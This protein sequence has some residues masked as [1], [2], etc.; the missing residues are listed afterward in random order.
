MAAHEETLFIVSPLPSPS[1]ILL[2]GA[3][4][5]R[6]SAFLT[7]NSGLRFAPFESLYC[8]LED[9]IPASRPIPW[10]LW[11]PYVE[12]NAVALDQL[13]FRQPGNGPREGDH[14]PTRQAHPFYEPAPTAAG[15][16]PDYDCTPCSLQPA[17]EV[18]TDAKATRIYEHDQRSGINVLP[19]LGQDFGRGYADSEMA[20][21]LFLSDINLYM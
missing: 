18:L 2:P 6:A 21:I 17:S 11:H 16:R 5:Q 8:P 4:P 10:S 15:T 12:R 14:R 9:T 19:R 3:L 7:L 13:A 20:A 1:P